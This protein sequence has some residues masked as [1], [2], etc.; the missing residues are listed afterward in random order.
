MIWYN[1][2][3]KPSIEWLQT[4]NIVFNL[5]DVSH[6]WGNFCL[7]RFRKKYTTEKYLKTFG[8]SSTLAPPPQPTHS[9]R[10]GCHKFLYFLSISFGYYGLWIFFWGFPPSLLTPSPHFKKKLFSF[11]K[12]KWYRLKNC[13][14][15][16]QEIQ[17]P[18]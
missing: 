11:F 8:V 6:L 9:E 18:L 2:D 7:R 1:L 16:G 3:Y 12:K 5:P 17:C 14:F 10:A 13:T 15:W 4:W